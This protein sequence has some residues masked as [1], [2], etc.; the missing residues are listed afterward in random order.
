MFS[1]GYVTGWVVKNNA[2]AVDISGYKLRLEQYRESIELQS[3]INSR[4]TDIVDGITGGNTSA[5]N[6]V[7]R[8]R[9]RISELEKALRDIGVLVEGANGSNIDTSGIVDGSINY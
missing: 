4:I 7:Q 2:S 6:S 9:E 1:T 3:G 5:I 8:I